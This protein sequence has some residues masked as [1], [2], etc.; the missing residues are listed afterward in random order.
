MTHP[1]AS[2][3]TNEEAHDHPIGKGLPTPPHLDGIMGATHNLKAGASST[4]SKETPL[5]TEIK[6]LVNCSYVLI[7]TSSTLPF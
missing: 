4:H 3:F 1:K 6:P 2:H 5:R 7:F